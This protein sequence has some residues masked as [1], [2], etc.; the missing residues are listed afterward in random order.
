M[1]G[2]RVLITGGTGLLGKALLEATP[3]GWE[4]F[5]THC[6]NQPPVEWESRFSPLDVR[7]RESVES[8]FAKIRPDWVIHTASIGSVDE[9]ERNP[10]AVF[11]VNVAGTRNIGTACA[12]TGAL[13]VHISSN[14][15]FDGTDP[16]YHEASLTRPANQYGT[17]KIEAEEWIRRHLSRFLII[18][19]I[20]MYGWP[21]P[22]GRDN[23][24][25]RWLAHLEQGRTVPA[26]QDLFSMPLWVGNGA[27]AIWA[28]VS[29][30]RQGIYHLAGADPLSLFEFAQ[31]TAR[32]FGLEERLVLP[33]TH[34]ELGLPAPRPQN[35]SFVTTKMEQ[36]LGV[37]PV[38]VRE[39]LS[40][41]QKSRLLTG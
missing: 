20:L 28:A 38:G 19:P 18:R 5:A 7:Q 1:S 12:Q 13:L 9:A 21:F 29:Q 14:A 11:A 35:T 8:L 31:E 33:A 26:A 10:D 2:T 39:G 30:G 4:I 3:S 22:G 36:E 34:A 41:M 37:R 40:I 6:R 15:V 27:E 32:A 16:P 23:V 25:T 17:Q 24:V